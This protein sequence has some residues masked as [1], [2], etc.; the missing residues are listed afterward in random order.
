MIPPRTIEI[1]VYLA[2]VRSLLIRCSARETWR[3][4]ATSVVIM[5][6]LLMHCCCCVVIVAIVLVAIVLVNVLLLLMCC[7]CCC[8]WCFID[9]VSVVAASVVSVVCCYYCCCLL[10]SYTL[11]TCF[12]SYKTIFKLHAVGRRGQLGRGGVRL[13]YVS[14]ELDY[15]VPVLNRVIEL[16]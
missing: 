13:N 1:T 8:K 12:A 7:Y 10:A 16:I 9:V 5:L 11:Q 15:F 4:F 2:T 14:T 3:T 6:L